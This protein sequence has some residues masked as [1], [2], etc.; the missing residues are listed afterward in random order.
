MTVTETLIQK[1]LELPEARREEVLHFVENLGQKPEREEG[2]PSQLYG[3]CADIRS[4]LTFEDF[5]KVRQQM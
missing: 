1:I 5:K 2:R 3:M 4:D